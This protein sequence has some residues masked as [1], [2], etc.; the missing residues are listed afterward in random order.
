MKNLKSKL[1]KE[2]TKVMGLSQELRKFSVNN[3]LKLLTA[4][5][6]QNLSL[7]SMSKA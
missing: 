3:N 6:E 7:L 2:E 5:T 4:G 1:K